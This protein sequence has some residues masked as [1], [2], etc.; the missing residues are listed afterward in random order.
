MGTKSAF[1]SLIFLVLVLVSHAQESLVVRTDRDLYFAGEPIWLTLNCMNSGSSDPSDLSKVAYVEVLNRNNEPVRQLKLFLNEGSAS[2]QFYLPDT[3]STSN[4]LLRAYTKWMRNYNPELYFSKDIAVINPFSKNPFPEAEYVFQSDTV[5]FY[6][7]GGK[8]VPGQTNRFLVKSFKQSGQAKA[9]SGK[10]ISPSGSNVKEIE[11][12]NNGITAFSV[13]VSEQGTYH[14]EKGADQ[15]QYAFQTVADANNIT[16]RNDNAKQI[17]FEPIVNFLS[18]DG[19]QLDIITASGVLVKSYPVLEKPA[20]VKVDTDDLPKGYLCALLFDKAGKVQASRYFIVPGKITESSI[21]IQNKTDGVQNR[22]KVTLQIEKPK[23]LS[24]VTVSVV[25]ES[26]VNYKSHLAFATS[27][28]EIPVDY[29]T[30]AENEKVSANDLLIAYQPVFPIRTRTSDMFLPE[31]KGEIISGTIVNL[32]TQEPIREE[33][34]MLSFVGKYPTLDLYKTD[35]NG[36]F[37]FET[38]RFGEQEIVI[39]PFGNDSV[40]GNYKVNLDLPY[41]TSYPDRNVSPFFVDQENMS[42]INSAIVGMQVN[43]LYAADN[44]AS[45]SQLQHKNP[46]AFYG[47]P[48][49][50]TSLVDYIELPNMEE[51]IREIVPQ[52]TPVKKD[53]QFGI[54]IAEGELAYSRDVNSFCLVD[55]VPVKNQNNIFQMNAQRVERIDVENRDVFVKSY[56]IGKI[57]SLITKDGNMGAFDFDKRIFRQSFHAYQPEFDFHSPDY[58]DEKMKNSRIPDFRNVLYWNPDVSFSDQNRAEVQFFTSDE[59][60]IYKVVVEGINSEGML[61]HAESRLEVTEEL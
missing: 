1:I 7:E 35:D 31:L 49:S 57:F 44:P 18:T 3:L 12:G 53:D 59:S 22:S 55:G 2:T 19:W 33:T 11:C 8:V 58:S 9:T 47:V 10:I 42:R 14:F 20:A 27:P 54:A 26:L 21:Q 24:N 37:Y 36:R 16:L 4:Y 32:V 15:S 23:D 61:E 6:P 5:F 52:V 46:P 30:D 25:K 40:A 13:Q 38:N 45:A 51:I 34:F 50:S 43:L 41:C 17:V 48:N 60:A 28:L 39:Q 29:F 56:K